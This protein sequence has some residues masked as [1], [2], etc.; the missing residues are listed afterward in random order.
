MAVRYEFYMRV[1][2]M[3]FSRWFVRSIFIPRPNQNGKTQQEHVEPEGLRDE[4]V[5][6]TNNSNNLHR[7]HNLDINVGITSGDSNNVDG[8]THASP[9]ED[10]RNVFLCSL[11]VMSSLCLSH[12]IVWRT[13]SFNTYTVVNL[14]L[15]WLL[16]GLFGV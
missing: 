1:A 15:R 16:R 5:N 3:Y 8:R 6:H 4:L 7:P 13:C 12:F 2:E 14:L 11:V 9:F 10:S